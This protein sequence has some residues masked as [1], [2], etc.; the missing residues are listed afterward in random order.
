MDSKR[1]WLFCILTVLSLGE[2]ASSAP[3]SR[4]PWERVPGVRVSDFK[5]DLTARAEALLEEFR[6]YGKCTDTVAACLR[7]DT[8]SP[9]AQR[10]ARDVFTLLSKGANRDQAAKWVEMRM[11]MATTPDVRTFKL[12]SATPLGNRNAP[13]VF[14]EFSDFQCPSC[15]KAAPVLE[16]LVRRSGGK[17]RLYFKQFPLKTHP[18]SVTLAKACVAS[19]TL[20]KFWELCPRLFEVGVKFSEDR[21]WDLARSVGL[22]PAKL[23][24]EMQRES[25]LDR[26]TDD[27]MEGLKNMISATPSIF[28]NGKE[29]LLPVSLELLQD[30]LEEELDILAGKV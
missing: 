21:L 23:K 2:Q 12:D 16:E 13:I 8:P 27:K 1:I 24:D 22:D 17:A 18:D 29:L 30:R 26:I 9:T 5:P 4:F 20:G 10:L 11:R 6:S 28:I 7:K 25:V 3:V 15:V 19:G 14:V